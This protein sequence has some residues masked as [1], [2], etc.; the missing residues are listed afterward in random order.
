MNVRLE[1]ITG[2]GWYAETQSEPTGAWI[3][4]SVALP[5]IDAA[6]EHLAKLIGKPLALA[7]TEE[8]GK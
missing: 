1:Y 4:R 5:T 8:R 6:V 2:R 3:F 7:L